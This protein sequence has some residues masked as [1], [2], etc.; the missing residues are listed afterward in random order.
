MPKKELKKNDNEIMLVKQIIFCPLCGCA[1]IRPIKDK[2]RC[3]NCKAMFSQPKKTT[4]EI[5]KK[6]R[7]IG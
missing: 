3:L 2:F 1:A 6:P 4:I 7:Y 5:R